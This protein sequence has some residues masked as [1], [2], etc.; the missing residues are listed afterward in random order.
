MEII[1]VVNY[2]EL[3]KKAAEIICDSINSKKD[4]NI[5]F[6]SG[7]TPVG[8]FLELIDAV[9]NEIVSFKKVK[10]F[11][12]DEYC[13]IRYNKEVSCRYFVNYNLFSKIDIEQNNVYS[14]NIDEDDLNLSCENYNDLLSANPLDLLVLGIGANGHIGF[15]EP[16]S[17]F[18]AECHISKLAFKTRL[19]NQKFFITMNEAPTH[20]LTMGLKNILAAKKI[21][22]LISGTSKVD[23][24]ERLMT[25][26]INEDFPASVLV[27][28]PN[29]TVI[30]DSSAYNK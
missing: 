9:N 28:H 2:E 18:D 20:A 24:V 26:E 3:S 1:K 11:L 13:G 25:L 22:L 19:D 6:P 8:M 12:L 23:A 29:V 27:N 15:N 5:A 10:A 17:S 14:P 4:F 7:S 30:I 16:G 21:I